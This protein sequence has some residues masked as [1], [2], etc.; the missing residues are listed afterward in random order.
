MGCA[1][2]NVH[3]ELCNEPQ[4]TR[5]LRAELEQVA[6]ACDL[7]DEARFELKL[8]ATEALTNSFKGTASGEHSVD[9]M[10]AGRPG[11]VDV[12]IADRGRFTPRVR[13]EQ[14]ALDAEG[15]RG[16]PLMLALVDEVEFASCRDGTRVRMTKRVPRSG[17]G[18]P[19]AF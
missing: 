12:E 19:P 17:E 18:G 1:H 14:S 8:A 5:R 13:S 2:I 4:S 6:S 9:V 11:A 15:G 16:I 7:A 10:I 3:L